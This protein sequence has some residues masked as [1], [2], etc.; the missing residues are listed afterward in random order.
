MRSG[1]HCAGYA[2]STWRRRGDSVFIWLQLYKVELYK[3]LILIRQFMN[4]ISN[5]IWNGIKNLHIVNI[6]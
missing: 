1:Y 5:I 4:I 2:A 3:I 6:F